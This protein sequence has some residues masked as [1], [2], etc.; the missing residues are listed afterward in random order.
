MATDVI[1]AGYALTAPTAYT[2]DAFWGSPGHEEEIFTAKVSQFQDRG[3]DNYGQLYVKELAGY[4]D[5]VV[6]PAFA[7]S[8]DPNDARLNAIKVD[9]VSGKIITTKFYMQD[10]IPGMYSPKLLRL[11]EMYF[12]RAEAD[13]KLGDAASL[14]E[15][16]SDLST[17][18]ANR[19]LPN[20]IGTPTLADVL[21]EKNWEFAFEGFQWPDNF[22]NGIVTNRPAPAG[23]LNNQGSSALPVTDNRQLYPIPQREID[24]NPGIRSQQNPGY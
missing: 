19:N 6:T 8:Y 9:A 13:V 23:A 20:Y 17:V 4:G 2:K 24:A 18:R 12:I 5:I 3:S 10:H 14:T 21:R 11:A 1:N 7:N 22:R 15:A 16:A